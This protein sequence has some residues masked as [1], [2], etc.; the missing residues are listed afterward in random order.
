M[1]MTRTAMV[2]A[3]ALALIGVLAVGA[4]A[5]TNDD[6][7]GG[8]YGFGGPW[9][10]EAGWGGWREHRGPD[11]E[12]VRAVRAEL[13]ADLA[14]ELD[15]TPEEVEAAFRGVA[16]QRVDEAVADGRVDAAAVDDVLAAYD[17]GDLG[18]IF[19]IVKGGSSAPTTEGS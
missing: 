8:G 19:R 10:H 18:E 6:D 2:G 16:E 4:Y 11:P 12:R 9:R 5:L 7:G 14:G 17:R 15:A 1:R 13:A 3:V